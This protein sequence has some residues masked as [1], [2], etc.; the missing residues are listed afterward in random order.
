MKIES[1]TAITHPYPDGQRIVGVAVEY[2]TLIRSADLS[3]SSF[4]V[5]E[6]TVKEVYASSVADLGERKEEGKFAV[7][8]LDPE[9]DCNATCTDIEGDPISRI[10]RKKHGPRPRLILPDGREFHGPYGLAKRRDP[11]RVGVRQV[12]TIRTADAVELE[13]WQEELFSDKENNHIA[14]LF[15]QAHFRDVDYNLFIPEDY[16]PAKKYPLVLFIHDAGVMGVNPRITL[17][18]GIGATIW[19]TPEEQAKHPCFILAPQHAKELPITNDDYEATEDLETIKALCDEL[20]ERYSIDRD[21]IYT[22]GQSMG[23]MTSL[24]L[25]IR[26]PDYF[27]AGLVPAG[28]WDLERTVKLWPLN[29]WMFLSDEDKGGVRMLVLPEM[30]EKLGGKIGFYQ[31]SADQPI[32][33]LSELV[34]EVEDD[35][36]TFHLTEFVG[37]TIWRRSQPDRTNGGGHNGTWH[38]VYQIEAVRDWLFRQSK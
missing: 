5:G 26:Y 2:D 6:R 25:M 1:I 34:E 23:F 15:T 13:P 30:A 9:D 27:A 17:E 11:L 19:A 8:A 10:H 31:W 21:R 28:H 37:D 16:D 22:T 7:I 20:T 4:V 35:G 3:L 32:S 38:L 24:E 12:E 18:Q 36:T 14:D 33:R 29:L